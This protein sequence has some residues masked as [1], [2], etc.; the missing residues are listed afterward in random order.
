MQAEYIIKRQIEKVGCT[1][2]LRDGDWSSVT[3]KAVVS[4]LWRRKSSNFEQVLTQLGGS[5]SEYFLYIGSFDHNIQTLS[6]SA[7]LIFDDAQYEFKHRSIVKSG[8]R[9]LYF[10]GILRRLEEGVTYEN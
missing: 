5:R 1:V 4:P 8:D 7:V 10:T 9:L 2:E 3:F 6:D